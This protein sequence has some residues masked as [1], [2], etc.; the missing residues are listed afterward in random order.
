MSRAPRLRPPKADL[1]EELIASMR[2][3]VRIVA[4]ELPPVRV[5]PWK[6][7]ELAIYSGA[8]GSTR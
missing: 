6:K 3:A 1:M 2:E 7:V 8:Y 5:S 4:G